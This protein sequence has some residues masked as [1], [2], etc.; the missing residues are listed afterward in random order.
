MRLTIIIA[1]CAIVTAGAS[2]ALADT[3]E[4]LTKAIKGD[5]SETRL[6]ALAEKQGTSAKVRSFGA[7]LERDHRQARVQAAPI[8]K[9]HQVPLTEAMSDEAQNEFA[10]LQRLHGG[11]FDR[12]F[13]RYMVE[14]HKKDIAD[15]EK[16][17]TSGDP[18]DVK[19][20]ARKTLPTLRKHL[21]TAQSIS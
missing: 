11:A 21:K 17:A 3:S 18:E 2:P 14:D 10:V 7:M 12:E 9:R 16:E 4:F 13:G 5:N 15:F 6:G 8:A 1:T 19:A 20:L